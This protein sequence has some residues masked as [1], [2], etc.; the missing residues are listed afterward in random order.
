MRN[1]IYISGKITGTTDYMERF[2]NAE[3]YLKNRG[4]SPVNHAKVNSMMPTDTTYEEY[5]LMS[6]AMLETCNSI[7][8]LDGWENSKGAR[9]EHERSIEKG[10]R[11]YY[12]PPA[13]KTKM[14]NLFITR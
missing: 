9:M 1:R 8:M 10:I 6:F 14:Y 13:W 5:M 2:N 12:Q 7:Y 3:Q 11:I 4:F